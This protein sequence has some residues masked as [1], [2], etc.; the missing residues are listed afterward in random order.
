MAYARRASHGGWYIYRADD[1]AKS[2]D[3]SM[4]SRD[5]ALLFVQGPHRS[6]LPASGKDYFAY[7]EIKEMVASQDFSSVPGYLP[8]DH[9]IVNQAF[10]AF[11]ADVE[12]KG[13]AT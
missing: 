9:G 3:T 7:R 6:E 13:S 8:S 12:G 2:S 1:S 11:V 5:T 10:A 4:A